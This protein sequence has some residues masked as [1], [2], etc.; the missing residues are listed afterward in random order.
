[1]ITQPFGLHNFKHQPAIL[2]EDATNQGILAQTQKVNIYNVYI[3]ST[4][5]SL[6]I[7]LV[8]ICKSYTSI[9]MILYIITMI[10]IITITSTETGLN[11]IY[12]I[13]MPRY[14]LNL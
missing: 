11:I 12:L 10:I 2:E 5:L 7:Q 6:Y 9:I 14:I 3:S 8:L 13:S 4:C 1:M